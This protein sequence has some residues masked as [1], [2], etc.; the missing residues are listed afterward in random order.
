[1][2]DAVHFALGAFTG[3]VFS[4]LVGWGLSK[5][6]RTIIA[7]KQSIIEHLTRQRDHARRT[8]SAVIL[9]KNQLRARLDALLTDTTEVS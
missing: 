8:T 4:A 6:A 5:R 2:R 9:D 3:C 7:A 1:M